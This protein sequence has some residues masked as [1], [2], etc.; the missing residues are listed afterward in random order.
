MKKKYTDSEVLSILKKLH[1]QIN[2]ANEGK[3]D[4]SSAIPEIFFSA[5]KKP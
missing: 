4:K 5:H 3:V 2:L 1:Q